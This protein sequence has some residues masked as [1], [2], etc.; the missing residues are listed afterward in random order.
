MTSLRARLRA[1]HSF[2]AELPPFPV[3]DVPSAPLPLLREWLEAAL[4]AGVLLPHAVTL[5]TVAVDG[6]AD[7]RTL[8]VKDVTSD[9][10]VFATRTDG[11]KVA[12]LE[13]V[14]HAAITF[15]WRELG[16]QVRVRGSV[17][18]ESDE[19]AR[20]D[21]GAR[22]AH[23]RAAGR[24]GTQSSPMSSRS[25]Y[26]RLFR[27]EV[28]LIEAGDSTASD[29]WAVFTVVPESIEFWAATPDEGQI[30]LAY[31]LADGKWTHSLLWP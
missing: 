19:V 21:E 14:P 7:A 5:S 30:R 11:I 1:V 3:E 6:T 16:R 17:R 25:D 20:A 31:E 29:L 13:R 4:D 10:V 18:R 15:Y 9:G 28:E 12:E 23:S 26:V 27:A 2:Q 24:M 22:P 8:I